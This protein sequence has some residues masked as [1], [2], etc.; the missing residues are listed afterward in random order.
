VGQ[1]LKDLDRRYRVLHGIDTGRGNVDHVV[2]GPTGVFAIETKNVAGRFELRRERVAHNGDDASDVLRQAR[3]GALAIRDR[4]REAGMD[5]WV[6]A[7]M[8]SADA[9]VRTTAWR[10]RT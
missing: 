1:I 3:A 10:A 8:V 9:P 6:E 2:I 5:R 4:L 7:I